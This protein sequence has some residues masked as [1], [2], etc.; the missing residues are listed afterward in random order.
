MMNERFF[1]LKDFK[2]KVVRSSGRSTHNDLF[3]IIDNEKYITIDWESLKLYHEEF[4]DQ[5]AYCML[6]EDREGLYDEV[7]KDEFYHRLNKIRAKKLLVKEEN[8]V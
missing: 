8:G 2:N 5:P 6:I 1:I 3:V 7:E 4:M